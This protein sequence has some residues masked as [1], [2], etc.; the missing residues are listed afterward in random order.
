MFDWI[1]RLTADGVTWPEA[2]LIVFVLALASLLFVFIIR[3]F[4]S[5]LH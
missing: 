3:A 4:T 5:L 1:A 2:F